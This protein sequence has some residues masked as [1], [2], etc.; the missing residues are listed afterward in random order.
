MCPRVPLLIFQ[1]H[2][3]GSNELKGTFLTI[4]TTVIL[5][6]GNWSWINEPINA[7]S[8]RLF[9]RFVF[10]FSGGWGWFWPRDLSTTPPFITAHIKVQ[11]IIVSLQW[12]ERVKAQPWWVYPGIAMGQIIFYTIAVCYRKHAF[13]SLC[14][15][16]YQFTLEANIDKYSKACFHAIHNH[17]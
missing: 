8:V 9:L 4:L 17:V 6:I 15:L 7:N 11:Q 5:P 3:P 12:L 14:A 10:S 13:M 16:L 2:L 1:P